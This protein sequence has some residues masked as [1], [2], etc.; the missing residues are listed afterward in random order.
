LHEGTACQNVCSMYVH[1]PSP[2]KVAEE[3][4]LGT[5]KSYAYVVMIFSLCVTRPGE[6]GNVE[7]P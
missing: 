5:N 2:Q 4:Q 1:L 7:K 3:P 6:T